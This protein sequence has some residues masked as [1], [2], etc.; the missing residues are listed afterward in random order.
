VGRM[1]DGLPRGLDGNLDWLDKS[2]WM[3][4]PDIPRVVPRGVL[5]RVQRL[6]ALGNAVVP[7]QSYPIFAAIAEIYLD[8]WRD[9]CE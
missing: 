9:D 8:D 7:A 1:A 2:W 5:N 3:N 4:E 6:R